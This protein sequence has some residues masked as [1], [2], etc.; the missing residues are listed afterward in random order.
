M[1]ILILFLSTYLMPLFGGGA[2][3]KA[4]GSLYSQASYSPIV[5]K[6]YFDS[7]GKAFQDNELYSRHTLE[8]YGELGIYQNSTAL[9]W[10]LPIL[11]HKKSSSS[12]LGIG[13][14]YLGLQHQYLKSD[15]KLGVGLGG[16][17]PSPQKSE[18]LPFSQSN[19]YFQIS[20]Y[21]SYHSFKGNLHFLL[22]EEDYA[23]AYDFLYQFH[24]YPKLYLTMVIRGQQ[25]TSRLKENKKLG[26]GMNT[27]Y[28]APGIELFYSLN[29]NWHTVAAFYTGAQMKNIY[30]FPG[31][32]MG[33]AY[34]IN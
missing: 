12:Q 25:K 16:H 21:L 17:L 5:T 32:K 2:D 28:I 22:D 6:E 20:H 18:H 3:G 19:P 8:F 26:Y 27:E 1:K 33:I 34:T 13:S 14:S 9:V 7:E 11:L 31:I 4:I 15:L 24:P 10:N 30:A 29:A 23:W